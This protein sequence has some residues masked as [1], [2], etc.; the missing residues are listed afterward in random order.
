MRRD[1]LTIEVESIDGEAIDVDH[2]REILEGSGFRLRAS[3]T[4]AHLLARGSV[5]R[6][7]E[8]AQQAAELVG[9]K[10]GRRA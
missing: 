8:A 3:A 5:R 4:G 2:L 1:Y 6:M 10:S 9:V 7:V